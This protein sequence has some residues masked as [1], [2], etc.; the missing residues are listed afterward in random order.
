MEPQL[1]IK[2]LLHWKHI[3]PPYHKPPNWSWLMGAAVYP[4]HH[5][6]FKN[7]HCG[8]NSQF[9]NHTRV[10]YF[11]MLCQSL[12]FFHSRWQV[13]KSTQQW[14][15]DTD[16]GKP[17]RNWRKACPGGITYSNHYVFTY[18]SHCALKG[19]RTSFENWMIDFMLLIS[20][21]TGI[22]VY[23]SFY[24]TTGLR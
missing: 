23:D 1:I 7:L 3:I 14:R 11:T 13:N 4:K 12:S 9:F 20:K 21:V 19:Y 17:H 6:E 8:Q 15:N 22:I 5:M 18:N 10:L 16:R 24:L 2:L